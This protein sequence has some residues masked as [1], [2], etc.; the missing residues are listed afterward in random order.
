MDLPIETE[1]DEET[2]AEFLV[3]L[4]GL[5]RSDHLEPQARFAALDEAC[6]RAIEGSIAEATD[7]LDQLVLGTNQ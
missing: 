3:A 6:T 5:A 7:F 1:N 2:F 4:Q